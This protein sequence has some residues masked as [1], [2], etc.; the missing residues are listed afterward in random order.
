MPQRGRGGRIALVAVIVA[1]V[2]AA[3]V[4]IPLA[5]TGGEEDLPRADGA[6]PSPSPAASPTPAE[7]DQANFSGAYEVTITIASLSSPVQGLNEGDTSTST[8]ILRST[9]P[10]GPCPTDLIG[11]DFYGNGVNAT[12]D[13]E[14]G[15]FK[16]KTESSLQCTDDQTGEVLFTYTGPGDFRIRITEAEVV[17]GVPRAIAFEGEFVFRYQA[18]GAPTGNCPATLVERDSISVMM[19]SGR[20]RAAIAGVL[21]LVLSVGAACTGGSQ[22]ARGGDGGASPSPSP[23]P[24]S[25]ARLEGTWDV[26]LIVRE[27]EG[28]EDREAGDEFDRTYVF[29]PDCAEGPCGG[30]LVRE[31][32]LGAFEHQ[33]TY[34]D[35]RYVID[36]KNDLACG[37]ET[38]TDDLRM[39]LEV[40]DAQQV[41]GDL[42]ATA[43][44]GTLTSIGK[45]TPAAEGLGCVDSREL[46]DLTGTL[47]A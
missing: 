45:A 38:V 42:I 7:P 21:G 36:E 1:V 4:A 44:E 25:S 30:T 26:T 27:V 2:I 18:Q 16:G 15:I 24:L 41:G 29:V 9:C 11:T 47:A 13:L 20:M 32:G 22:G 14:G 28:L 5:L 17:D 40:T 19:R 34:E 12:G 35:G 6:K 33:F 37:S 10:A 31:G 39:E 43:M 3:A 46:D 23:Q 8:W